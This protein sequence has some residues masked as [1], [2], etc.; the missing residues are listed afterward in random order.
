VAVGAEKGLEGLVFHERYPGWSKGFAIE[1][2]NR[3]VKNEVFK[4]RVWNSGN[5]SEVGRAIINV[6]SGDRNIEMGK[7]RGIDVLRSV[8]RR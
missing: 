6:Q 5:V 3:I 2:I 8:R 7:H 1:S 4:T